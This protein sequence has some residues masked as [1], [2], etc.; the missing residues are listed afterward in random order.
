MNGRLRL[1]MW[2]MTL[3]MGLYGLETST[4]RGV[5]IWVGHLGISFKRIPRFGS[6]LMVK[7]GDRLGI[8]VSQFGPLVVTWPESR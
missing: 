4:W 6:R 1:K 2:W 5:W 7:R 3:L 8:R